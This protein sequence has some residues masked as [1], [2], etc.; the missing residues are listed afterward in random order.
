MINWLAPCTF[1]QL[2]YI[3]MFMEEGRELWVLFGEYGDVLCST[4]NR[5]EVFFAAADR[6]VK[7]MMLN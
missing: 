6:E 3:R 1:Y 2:G 4:E 5:S 7:V